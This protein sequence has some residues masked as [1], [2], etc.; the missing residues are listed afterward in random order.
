[1]SNLTYVGKIKRINQF[2]QSIQASQIVSGTI[3][4]K[5]G[6][7]IGSPITVTVPTHIVNK[8]KTYGR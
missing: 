7:V 6:I 4:V 3:Y 5:N 2:F 1:M 8:L